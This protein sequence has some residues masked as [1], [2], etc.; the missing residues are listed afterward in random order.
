VT[1]GVR[2]GLLLLLAVV[3]IVIVVMTT[4]QIVQCTLRDTQ[5]LQVHGGPSNRQQRGRC[6]NA[7]AVEIERLQDGIG[8]GQ[9]R[10]RRQRRCL[11]I[12]QSILG[13]AE[14]GRGSKGVQ[15]GRHG[16]P[17]GQ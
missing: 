14:R 10:R 4:I 15:Q 2:Q 5:F 9:P 1:K 12:S 17:V 7:R 11:H 3:S 6:C 16:G 13:E 8:R